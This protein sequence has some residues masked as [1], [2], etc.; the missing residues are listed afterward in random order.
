[1]VVTNWSEVEVIE[2]VVDFEILD[3]EHSVVKAGEPLM[4][5]TMKQ[6]ETL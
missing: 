5:V 1:M 4:R 3:E 2:N 6:E